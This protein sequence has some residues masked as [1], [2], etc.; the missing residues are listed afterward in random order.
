[1]LAKEPAC[2]T[3]TVHESFTTWSRGFIDCA[4][5]V[6]TAFSWRAHGV[7]V[8]CPV[9]LSPWVQYDYSESEAA[10]GPPCKYIRVTHCT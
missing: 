2:S 6:L 9:R 5:C 4:C 10:A 8:K 7:S 3:T 1:M